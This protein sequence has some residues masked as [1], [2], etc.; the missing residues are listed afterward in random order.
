MDRECI[1][2][3]GFLLE[4]SLH[5]QLNRSQK[6][7]N[8]LAL[9]SLNNT[10]TNEEKSQTNEQ[11]VENTV[12]SEEQSHETVQETE[13]KGIEKE[14]EKEKMSTKHDAK[15]SGDVD[16]NFDEAKRLRKE[17]F[18]ILNSDKFEVDVYRTI[19]SPSV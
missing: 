9:H 12:N 2:N 19:S 6:T 8:L 18:N 17:I 14:E 11:T 5:D 16:D 4:N 15:G 10:D 7:K 1:K 3:N 13:T